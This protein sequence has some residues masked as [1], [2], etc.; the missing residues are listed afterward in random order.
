MFRRRLSASAECS[1]GLSSCVSLFV[2]EQHVKGLYIYLFFFVPDV[3]VFSP[4]KGRGLHFASLAR[5]LR[6]VRMDRA[7]F[8]VKTC[9]CCCKP[10]LYS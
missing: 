2:N 9:D 3:A 4:Q 6:G 5:P 1:V 8:C 7:G 10:S